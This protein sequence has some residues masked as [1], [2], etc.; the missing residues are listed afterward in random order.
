MGKTQ[1][2]V[3]VEEGERSR[4]GEVTKETVVNRTIKRIV[5]NLSRIA[6][7]EKR[8]RGRKVNIEK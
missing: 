3:A 5:E 2:T 4:K 7:K 1:E 6:F 8:R